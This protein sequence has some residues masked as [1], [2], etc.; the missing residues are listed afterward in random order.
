MCITAIDTYIVSKSERT[1]LQFK[2]E[3]CSM[4][5]MSA[6]SASNR[7]YASGDFNACQ[8]KHCSKGFRTAQIIGF[9]RNCGRP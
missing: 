4:S 7:A 8:P 9:G 1:T 5:I 2:V 3:F 6:P